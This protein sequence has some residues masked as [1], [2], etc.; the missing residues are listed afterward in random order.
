MRTVLANA[1]CIWTGAA[2]VPWIEGGHVAVRDGVIERVSAQP[3]EGDADATIDLAGCLLV[4]GLI[5]L[6]HHF[7]QAA[8]RAWPGLDRAGSEDWLVGLYPVWARMSDADHV[9]ACRTAIAELLLCGTTTSVDHAF[10]LGTESDARLA[11]EAEA[12]RELG[13]RL[14]LV[15]SALP[16]IGGRVEARLRES[17]PRSLERLLD[18]IDALIERSRRDVARFHEGSPGAMLRIDLGPSNLPYEH[19]ELLTELAR[20]AHEAGCGLHTH[21]HPRPAERDECRRRH[22]CEPIELLERANWLDHRTT[23]VHCT[24]LDDHE[25]DRFAAHRVSIAHCPRTVVRLGYAM[26]RL[27][28]WRERG[29]RVGFGADGG[30]SNDAGAFLDDVRLGMLLHRIGNTP[31]ERSHWLD[32]Q[33]ALRMATVDA[34]DILGRDELG[35]IVPGARADLAAFDLTSIDVAGATQAPIGGL[36]LAGTA[37]RAALTMVEGRVVVRAGKLTSGDEHA[38]AARTR[39]VSRRLHAG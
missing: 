24:E 31:Q 14:H 35:R 20:I 13:L 29:V 33:T 3:I 38:I 28:R 36:L 11:A 2:E 18:P 15:R 19:P 5:N 21:Y 25:I 34:A 17:D 4:P 22:G 27:G 26:P 8:T 7:F 16:T 1:R 9:D 32:A 37:T 23:F 30:A 10:L 39:A 6:H 12:A